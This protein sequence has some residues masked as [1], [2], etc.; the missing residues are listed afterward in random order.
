M[1]ALSAP[2]ISVHEGCC[3]FLNVSEWTGDTT[4]ELKTFKQ[5][6]NE[7]LNRTELMNC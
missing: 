1:A 5:T 3:Q 2:T 4:S 7:L 6:E